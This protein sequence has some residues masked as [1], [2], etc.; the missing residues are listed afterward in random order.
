MLSIS[1]RRTFVSSAALLLASSAGMASIDLRAA[2]NYLTPTTPSGVVTGDFDTDGDLDLAI[3]TDTPDKVSILTNKG[4]GTFAGPVN[5][6]I[7]NGSG[8]GH[9]VAADLDG[10]KDVDLAV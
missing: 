9:V 1:T 2:V 6:A 7:N 4:D 5:F 8:A 10:D 3:T